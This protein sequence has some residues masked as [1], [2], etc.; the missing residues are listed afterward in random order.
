MALAHCPQCDRLAEITD[1]YALA[2]TD[3]PLEHLRL[4]CPAGH[5]FTMLAEDVRPALAAAA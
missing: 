1:R 4:D 3:G 2:S 5:W